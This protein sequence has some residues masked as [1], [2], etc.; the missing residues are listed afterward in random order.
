MSKSPFPQRYV[1]P[2]VSPELSLGD[3]MPGAARRQPGEEKRVAVSEVVNA[4]EDAIE[5]LVQTIDRENAALESREPVDLPDINR[6][7]SHSLL[8]LT[9]RARALPPG[10]DVLLRD[11]LDVLR[12][13]LVQNHAILGLHVAAVR[14]IS[15]LMANVLG[16]AESDGTYGMTQQRRSA[17]R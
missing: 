3:Y 13:K 5:R 9:R 14:E 12:E 4:I 6:R 1:P 2:P 16:E 17:T 15:D 11:R 7:K 8:E 10:S